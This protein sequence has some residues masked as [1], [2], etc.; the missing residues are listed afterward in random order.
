MALDLLPTDVRRLCGGAVV[1]PDDDAYDAGRQ[2]WN[3]TADQRPALIAYP[4]DAREVAEVIAY[5]REAGLRVAPQATGHNALPLGDLSGTV[6]VRTAAMTEVRIDAANRRARVGA[7]VLWDDVVTAAAPH[8]LYPLH[9]SSPDVSVVGYS[10]GGGLGWL[11]RLHGLQANSVTA[12]ELVTAAG[13]VVRADAEHHAEL[14]WALRGG[15]G[16]FGIVTALEF[17]LYP[18]TEV[19]GGMLVWDASRAHDV[20][21]TWTAW[22]QRAPDAVTTSLRVL[23][24]PDVDG[25]PEPL[26][27]RHVVAVDG[28][29]VAAA[30]EAAAV[31]AP[32]RRL[33]PELD[34][35][36]MMPAA[37]LVRLH[38][39]PE[40]PMPAT[41]A[42]A[43]LD[44]LDEAGA[45]AFADAALAAGARGIMS[46]ELRQLGG[47]LGRPAPG[48]GALSHLDGAFALFAGSLTPEPAMIAPVLQAARGVIAAMAPWSSGRRYLNLTEEAVDARTAFDPE[49][50]ER[51][52]A[53]QLELDPDGL[54]RAN[55][56]LA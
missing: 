8:G 15:G 44:G 55:H 47:A 50:F 56:S 27:G 38:G 13:D 22:A 5:A 42:S 2:A 9:G 45:R 37:E 4:A 7:G 41:S 48:A 3:T 25:L 10:L 18:V 28:A 29:I 1:L 19:Y 32:L 11:A 36:G 52:R 40:E 6:L 26:R 21:A 20:I 31:L 24:L 46:C 43:L 49:T 17:E 30:P 14:F 39:D 34:T 23:A 53:L 12:V 16:N 33:A 51:L 35:F 54:V